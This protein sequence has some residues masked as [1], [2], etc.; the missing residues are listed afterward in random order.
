LRFHDLRHTTTSYLAMQGASRGASAF[1]DGIRWQINLA[2][3][4]AGALKTTALCGTGQEASRLH[5]IGVDKILLDETGL[6]GGNTIFHIMEL[7]AIRKV[8]Q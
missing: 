1:T 3:L 4:N 6:A 7:C 5:S 2:R 8:L